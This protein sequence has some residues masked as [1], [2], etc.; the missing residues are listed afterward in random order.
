MN[1]LIPLN[2]LAVVPRPRWVSWSACRTRFTA[3]KSLDFARGHD[4]DGAIGQPVHHSTGRPQAVFRADE[5]LRVL[6]RPGAVAYGG[7]RPGTGF[8][9][10]GDRV[11]GS[12]ELSLRLLEMGLT[13][14][15]GS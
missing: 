13:P 15:T 11:A 6:V 1:E 9:G 12:D 14:G 2:L 5:L 4:R 3:W 7:C 10:A 8:A